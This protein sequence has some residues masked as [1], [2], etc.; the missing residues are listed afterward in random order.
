[1]MLVELAGK[2]GCS[3]SVVSKRLRNSGQSSE[4]HGK[5]A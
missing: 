4:K 1:M 2:F 5:A 3:L